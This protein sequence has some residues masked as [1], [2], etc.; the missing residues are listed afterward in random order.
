MEE[1]WWKGKEEDCE[2]RLWKGREE[3]CEGR[4]W[5]GRKEASEGRLW[6]GREEDCEG[7]SLGS[8]SSFSRSNIIKSSSQYEGREESGVGS[9]YLARDSAV[10]ET[11]LEYAKS[12]PIFAK[13]ESKNLNNKVSAM[14]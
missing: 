7:S 6:K 2:G 3:Y 14:I 9:V 4:L 8:S 13:G 10:M 5:K 11:K 1:D 12:F